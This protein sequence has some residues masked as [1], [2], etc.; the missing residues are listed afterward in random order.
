MGEEAWRVVVA[1]SPGV[2]LIRR[3]ASTQ[4]QARP[5]RFALLVYHPTDPDPAL[6]HRRA[7]MLARAAGRV[8]FEQVVVVYPNN[9][10]GAGGII[11]CWQKLAADRRFVVRRDVRR[12]EFLAL[13]RDAAVMVGNSSSGI[14]EA[15]SF[16]TPVVDV[17]P[18]QAGRERS[19]NVTNVPF[20][21]AKVRAALSDAWN[22]GRPRRSR[23]RNVYGGDG[24]GRRIAAALARLAVNDRL[25]RKLVA[26]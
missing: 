17:G 14:I 16:G 19:G 25:L 22:N 12:P 7:E 23:A 26:Y 13:M 4:E 9:D 6:E 5:G 11:R 8:G 3:S 18:R 21:A 20:D 10:P 2:D 15:A 24:A 1:G